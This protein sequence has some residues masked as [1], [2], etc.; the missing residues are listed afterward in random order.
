LLFGPGIVN[1]PVFLKNMPPSKL[2]AVYRQKVLETH[3]DRA[4]VLGEME[5]DL[6][7][8]FKEVVS[9]YERLSLFL[10]NHNNINIRERKSGE[11]PVSKEWHRQKTAWQNKQ[12]SYTEYFYKGRMP[13]RKLLLGQYL[14]YSGIISWST[15]L[16]AIFWQRK[17]RPLIGQLAREWKILT[18]E[19][20]IK[21]LT[22]RK[23]NEKFADYAYRNGYIT[24]FEYLALI[25]R[26]RMLQRP[27]G[28]YFIQQK[29]LN[30]K[31]MEDVVKKLKNRNLD[32]AIMLRF[33]VKRTI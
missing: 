21:I 33:K 14:Y 23:Y 16:N 12:R 18:N 20:V 26:Q 2:K 28:E 1:V 6:V 25:G 5:S 11:E 29:I 19:D 7:K 17:Q 22:C 31:E 24:Y 4:K 13:K 27:I 3:P 15:L 8:R 9:A 30:T 10:N 32:I